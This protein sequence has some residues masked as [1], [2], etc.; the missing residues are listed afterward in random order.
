[1]ARDGSSF[2]SLALRCPIASLVWML[3]SGVKKGLAKP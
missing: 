1:M 3:R 2:T